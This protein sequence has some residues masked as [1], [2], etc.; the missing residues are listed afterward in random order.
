MRTRVSG[1]TLP[2]SPGPEQDRS[3]DERRGETGRLFGV[4]SRRR[5]A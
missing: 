3:A 2:T 1:E 5:E 4:D